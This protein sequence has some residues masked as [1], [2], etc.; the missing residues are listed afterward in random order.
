MLTHYPTV[1]PM[2]TD[3]HG[4]PSSEAKRI[5]R[6]HCTYERN[7]GHLATITSHGY[8]V[9]PKTD[10]KIGSN[11]MYSDISAGCRADRA[12]PAG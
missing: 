9:K 2:R 4:I 1:T 8:R 5:N 12:G 11:R 10:E 6:D 7:H 3:Q